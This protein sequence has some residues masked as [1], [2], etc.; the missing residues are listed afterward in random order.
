[1]GFILILYNMKFFVLL[2]ST[3]LLRRGI[4]RK[5]YMYMK[6]KML[7]D[8]TRAAS[9]VSG[10]L[11]YFV[12]YLYVCRYYSSTLDLAFHYMLLLLNDSVPFSRSSRELIIH[13]D[14]GSRGSI[15]ILSIF[16]II[17]REILWKFGVLSR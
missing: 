15:L 14:R 9:V 16:L 8:V 5:K 4:K 7:I 12:V 3:C 17:D 11:L 6:F 1:M 13:P 2:F 10:I